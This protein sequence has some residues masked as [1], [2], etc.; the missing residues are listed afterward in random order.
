[1][2]DGIFGVRVKD[3]SVLGARLIQPPQAVKG[4]SEVAVSRGPARPDRYRGSITSSFAI[5]HAQ[6]PMLQLQCVRPSK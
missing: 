4:D 6:A 5:C 1:M 3:S 2:G